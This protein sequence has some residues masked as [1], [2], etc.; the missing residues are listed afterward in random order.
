MNKEKLRELFSK[1]RM[2]KYKNDDEHAYNLYLISLISHK[3][4]ML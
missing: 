1:C 3:I 2:D 4:G